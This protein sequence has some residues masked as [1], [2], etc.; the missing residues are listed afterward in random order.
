MKMD[1]QNNAKD[2]TR[3]LEPRLV[4]KVSNPEDSFRKRDKEVPGDLEGHP[5]RRLM[6]KEEQREW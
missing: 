3:R 2:R 1:S 5:H 4:S 6:T